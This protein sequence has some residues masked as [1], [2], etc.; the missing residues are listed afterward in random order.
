MNAAALRQNTDIKLK[1]L[2]TIIIKAGNL[3][4][5]EIENKDYTRM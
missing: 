2:L 3:S 5:T 1:N 4:I